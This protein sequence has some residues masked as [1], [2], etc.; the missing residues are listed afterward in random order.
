MV[1]LYSI[2]SAISICT[3]VTRRKHLRHCH[4]SF[5][6]LASGGTPTGARQGTPIPEHFIQWYHMEPCCQSATQTQSR[7]WGRYPRVPGLRWRWRLVDSGQFQQQKCMKPVT[8]SPVH[9]SWEAAVA[10]TGRVQVP[11]VLGDA[12]PQFLSSLKV[13]GSSLLKRTVGTQTPIQDSSTCCEPCLLSFQNEN[14]F[15]KSH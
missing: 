4:C 8:L 15:I 10:C 3:F 12:R 7:L 2:F 6:T 14:Y 1:I 9:L 11:R 5:S 13:E